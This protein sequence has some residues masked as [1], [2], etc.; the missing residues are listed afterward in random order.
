MEPDE[1]DDLLILGTPR[2]FLR[3]AVQGG[4]TMPQAG[5]LTAWRVGLWSPA[6]EVRSGWS[7]RQINACLHLQWLVD[8]ERL[9]G[10]SDGASAND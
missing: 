9:G 7:L 10:P 6:V 8:R 3:R 5:A 1:F 2:A 4:W